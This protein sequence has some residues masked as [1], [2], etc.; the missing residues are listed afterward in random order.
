MG[1]KALNRILVVDRSAVSRE[2]VARMFRSGIS[3][4]E[5]ITCKTGAEALKLINESH[6]DLFTTSLMLSDIDGLDL[7]RQIRQL[8]SHRYT[9]VVVISGNA[10]NR[11]LKEGYAAGVTD[12][13]DK[14][15]GYHAFAKFIEEFDH[16]SQ[17]LTGQILYVEDSKTAAAITIPI[18]EKHGLQVTHVTSAEE[19]YNLINDVHKGRRE[20]F[21]LVATDFYL[22]FD[23]T[24]GD[25]LHAIRARMHYSRQ[26]LPVLVITGSDDSDTQVELFHAGANDFIVKPMVEEILMARIR[27]LL[28][29]K[30]QYNTL[31]SQAKDME[32]ISV[33][34]TLT[35]VFNRRFLMDSGEDLRRDAYNQPLWV[36][37]LDID[38][39]KQINDTQGHLVGDHVLVGL[40]KL[41]LNEMPEATPIRF[42][43]EEFVLLFPQLKPDD[44]LIR[45]EQLRAAV[46]ALN[47]FEIPVTV[48]IGAIDASQHPDKSLNE[49][50]KL[51]DQ[52]LYAAKANG[53]NRIYISLDDQKTVPIEQFSPMPIT[54]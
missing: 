4:S 43:G 22:E 13:F 36:T 45:L 18:L 17:W 44:A 5:V 51:A 54:E 21:D 39:F 15:Q 35:G 50:I 1:T 37:I 8:K 9:P 23:M 19:A 16:R 28:L 42:G 3:N 12:Y 34:D 14:S 6:F 31:Q 10:D 29:V 24:G 40:G 26:E 7:C 49:L 53:R 47:P 2:V 46:E 32:K 27:S 52:A 38:H 11:L 25:L 30:H 20:N 48:S 33:T 41:F